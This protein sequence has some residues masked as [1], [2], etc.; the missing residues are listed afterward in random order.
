MSGQ[1]SSSIALLDAHRSGVVMSSILHREQARVYVK[2]VSRASRSSSSRPRSSE[3][4][5]TA[6][7]GAP[8]AH[9]A[10]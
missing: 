9:R 8:A 10:G 7:A 6:L 4:I 3:A 5:D 1:Q 2:Q